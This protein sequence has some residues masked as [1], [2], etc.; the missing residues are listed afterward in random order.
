MHAK[1]ISALRPIPETKQPR[2]FTEPN[3][4]SFP[5]CGMKPTSTR[6]KRE[7]DDSS[8]ELPPNRNIIGGNMAQRGYHPWNVYI[9]NEETGEAC[10]GTL[11]SPTVI[12]TAAHCIYGSKAEDFI[13]SVG[14]Y[15]KSKRRAADGV[16]TR[17]PS[18][19]LT[20][21]KYDSTS[22]TSDIG[23]MILQPKI[24]ITGHVRPICLWNVDSDPKLKRVAGTEAMAV[25]FG[26]ADNYT[27]PDELQQVR[28]PIRTHRECFLSKRKFFGKYLR[29]GNNFCAGYTNGTSTCNGD[30]GGSLS[31]EKDS[32][33]F[34]R[35]I[36]SIGMSKRVKFNGE[37]TLLCHPDQYSLFADVASFMD[38]IVENTPEISFRN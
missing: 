30:S 10:G 14:M 32:R 34:I 1:G 7:I 6:T 2:G 13:V 22:Y 15:D 35:G 23:L 9:E 29:P 27:L 5:N 3:N 26:L 38:W 17:L 20:H 36:V 16:Q 28:L 8:E 18:R 33:W 37:E 19:L 21:P 4:L 31:V 12:L 11:I 25:G 24:K